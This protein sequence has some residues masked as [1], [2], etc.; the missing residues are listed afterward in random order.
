ML[1]TDSGNKPYEFNAVSKVLKL[2]DMYGNESIVTSEDGKYNMQLST[3]PIYA[4]ILDG[5]VEF[6]VENANGD[7]EVKVGTDSVRARLISNKTFDTKRYIIVAAY[8]DKQ[9]LG[10]DIKPVDGTALTNMTELISTQGAD[11]VK[12]FLMTES[13]EPELT[14]T[15][16]SK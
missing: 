7:A 12:A 11:T 4:E 6:T 14:S 15:A 16:N 10:V 5:Y 9:L 1:W 2:Y 3:S 8:K 13:F